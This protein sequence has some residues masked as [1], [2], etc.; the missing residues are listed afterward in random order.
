MEEVFSES[1]PVPDETVR[2]VSRQLSAD[3][4]VMYMLLRYNSQYVHF[5]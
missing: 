2:I 4:C 1:I 5:F 3:S